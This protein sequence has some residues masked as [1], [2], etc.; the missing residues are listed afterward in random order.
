MLPTRSLSNTARG[1]LLAMA[2]FAVSGAAA[3][4]EG[5]ITVSGAVGSADDPIIVRFTP[6]RADGVSGI[7][8]ITSEGDTA[9]VVVDAGGLA[10]NSANPV[11]LHA[12]TCD[13][14]SAS[15]GNLGTLQADAGGKGTLTATTMRAGAT[16]ADTPL[17][18]GLLADGEHVLVVAGQAIQACGPIPVA[19]MATSAPAQL[20][21]T[22]DPLTAAAATA[23]ALGL[24]GVA[25]G[26]WLRR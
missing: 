12:G 3:S 23:G 10:P 11:Y 20:P 13:A 22:G 16:G 1:L 4:A 19:A 21:Q 5:P 8:T 24:L 7:A 2:V 14:P 17:T 9:T 18:L 6:V 26:R 25:A 15:F